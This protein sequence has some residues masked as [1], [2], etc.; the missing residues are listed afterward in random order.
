MVTIANPGPPPRYP[1]K[2][3]RASSAPTRNAAL[4]AAIDLADGSWQGPPASK[5]GEVA[6][7]LGNGLQN[8]YTPVRIR[9]S[10]PQ[11]VEHE[12]LLGLTSRRPF[13]FG[14]QEI[15]RRLLRGAVASRSGA[16]I[17]GQTSTRH[18][19]GA[20]A[21]AVLDSNVFMRLATCIDA[22][23]LYTK[24]VSPIS[25]EAAYRRQRAREATVLSQFLHDHPTSEARRPVSIEWAR[26][27]CLGQ[28]TQA[29]PQTDLSS[30]SRPQVDRH[31]AD[32]RTSQ[33]S[34]CPPHRWLWRASPQLPGAGKERPSCRH[35][36]FR[37]SK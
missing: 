8:R 12:R 11:V 27:P 15:P 34:T 3:R 29:S 19:E 16:T 13:G 1:Y 32:S 37:H 36:R 4:P 10:P 35:G 33:R 9:S 20:K 14:I 7:R 25:P 5:H 31:D 28:V 21:V 30:C 18:S 2:I 6:K 23:S 24:G 22:G 17:M 26:R